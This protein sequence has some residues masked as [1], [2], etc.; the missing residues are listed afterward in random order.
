M[1]S[2]HPR[3]GLLA[4][5]AAVV[6][7]ELSAQL[8]AQTDP[9]PVETARPAATSDPRDLA[10]ASVTLLLASG[11]TLDDAAVV[12]VGAGKLPGTISSIT[13]E[14][15]ATGDKKIF[16]AQ[17]IRELKAAKPLM[18][19]VYDSELKLLVDAGADRE[20]L[21]ATAHQR[22]EVVRARKEATA[23]RAAAEA[24][25]ARQ[26]ADDA[27]AAASRARE[28]AVAAR[29][30]RELERK[31][32][33][34]RTGVWRW[35]ELTDDEQAAALAKQKAFIENA[36]KAF[37]PGVFRLYE[38]K[39]FLFYSDIPP[40]Y[41][42]M[43]TPYLDTMYKDLCKAYGVAAG[44]HVW[45]GKAMIFAFSQE[46]VYHQF[47]I[48]YFKQPKLGTQ[49]L[50]HCRS[51][52]TVL[53]S[54]YAGPDPKYLAT[55]MVHETA[56][57][58]THRF[59]S[60]VMVPNWLNEGASEWIAAKVVTTDTS[61]QRKIQRAVQVMQGTRSMGG[62]FFT[63]DHIAE[64]QY[65]I[66]A[67]ITDYLLRN[68]AKGYRQLLEA[69][70]DGTPWDQALGQCYHL[71]PGQLAQRYGQSIGIPDLKP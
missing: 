43:Y 63:V 15:S 42:N 57:G 68:D 71:T 18:R 65:G 56:H 40:V 35:P 41:V 54:C 36:G 29:Q 70:K 61:I 34:Q 64:W 44:T 46:L 50:A 26:R 47:E 48:A 28:D 19:F 12:K 62:D 45:L 9:S 27:K 52:G 10:G 53:I 23:S 69:I 21:H 3:L 55:V 2:L 25:E 17:A 6:V 11:K 4:L 5:L 24:E 30:Q 49:G 37:P 58:F 31:D 14:D 8:G 32:Y 7:F 33:F 39:Y 16:G 60:A 22:E 38:T 51:D 66:A 13:V 59:K 20:S 1:T 67:S